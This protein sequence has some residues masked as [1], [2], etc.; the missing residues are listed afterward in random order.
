MFP[1]DNELLLKT[2]QKVNVLDKMLAR[3]V[4]VQ[5]VDV[6]DDEAIMM[7]TSRVPTDMATSFGLDNPIEGLPTLMMEE[8]I[9]IKVSLQRTGELIKAVP[10]LSLALPSMANASIVVGAVA[11]RTA[12]CS[13]HYIFQKFS[14]IEPIRN[15]SNAW[16]NQFL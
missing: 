6:K 7:K 8:P 9:K 10:P 3:K 4:E 2:T 11:S 16:M 13:I 14:I 12:K 5:D 1:K 15:H